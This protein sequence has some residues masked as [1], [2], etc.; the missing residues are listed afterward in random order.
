M[1][2]YVT[3]RVLVSLPV[4]FGVTLV[5]FVL[6]N[7][8]PG[9]PATYFVNPELGG[10]AEQMAAVRARLGL[11]QPLEVRYV[12][13]LAE[14]ARGH[15]GYRIK[16][17][18]PVGSLIAQHFSATVLLVGVALSLGIAVGVSLGI[19]TA[20]RQ[21]SVW[22]YTLTAL[23]FLGVSMPAF[24]TGIFGLYTLALRLPL[25]PAGG[26][27]TVG[28]PPSFWDTL[29][30]VILPACMLSFGY[31][32]MF[33]R[34]TRFSMLEVLHQDFMAT[35]RAKGLGERRVIGVHAL[36]NALLPVVTAIGL[37]LP[38]LVVGAVFIETI[39]SWPGM[40]SLYLDAVQARDYPLIMGLDLVSAGAIL[41]T[42]LLTD[43]AY[44]LVDPRIR[45]R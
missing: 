25:F 5:V 6:V 22:D 19:V 43:V 20:L 40:G 27:V 8:M 37:S 29:Y 7:L 30:H 38:G 31:L 33:M 10:T 14:A 41:L 45:Y 15:L 36:R 12:K 34:Y 13:W 39:F 35:A 42:N 11:N 17:G 9:D 26:L 23:S 28:A 16:N 44:A 1:L 24:I 32:A 18:D 3:R 4:L 2:A 21:Y